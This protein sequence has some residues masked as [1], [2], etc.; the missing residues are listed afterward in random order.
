MP[1]ASPYVAHLP[2]YYRHTAFN[3]QF[4]KFVG[5]W[6]AATPSAKTA[7]FYALIAVA[8]WAFARG[9]RRVSAFEWLVILA[10]AISGVAAVRNAG[11]FAIAALMIVPTAFEERGAEPAPGRAAIAVA[12]VPL[13]LLAGLAVS[14]AVRMHDWVPREYPA[15]PARAVERLARDD[16]GARV[17]ADVRFADWL[18]WRS[19]SLAGRVAF[20]ARYELLTADQ[21]DAIHRFN[22][23]RGGGWQSA[24]RGYRIVVLDEAADG[25][26]AR[27]LLRR[28]GARL[29]YGS[30][31]G[32]VVELPA[33]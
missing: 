30:D 12:V 20:D 19:P 1:L 2:A 28:P 31:L 22:D 11:F 6:R 16:P 27:A 9:R 23:H 33:G 17:F 29:A 18:L 3:P 32:T 5:E 7:L 10:T 21:I 13:L 14:A 4:A 15:A 26:I 24:A 8:V 25:A